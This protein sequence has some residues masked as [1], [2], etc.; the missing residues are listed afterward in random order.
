MILPPQSRWL[1][2]LTPSKKNNK[3]R[4]WFKIILLESRKNIAKAFWGLERKWTM[5]REIYEQRLYFREMY[6]FWTAL[7][8]L[9][10][11]WALFLA[12][13]ASAAA[14]PSASCAS[15]VFSLASAMVW[16]MAGILRSASSAAVLLSFTRLSKSVTSS[17]NACELNSRQAKRDP[18]GS[19]NGILLYEQR[20][21]GEKN[22][23]Q[24]GLKS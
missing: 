9:S 22:K 13:V 17:R 2:I 23:K 4:G 24:H 18:S 16:L 3:R 14:L 8:I 1:P 15:L 11:S 5:V 12:S 21:S 20:K 19:C 7:A 6:T 10:A